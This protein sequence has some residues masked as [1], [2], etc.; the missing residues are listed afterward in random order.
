MFHRSANFESHDRMKGVNIKA[1]V[2][3]NI[4]YLG[5]RRDVESGLLSFALVLLLPLIQASGF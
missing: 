3:V 4:E 5:D 1:V 2:A